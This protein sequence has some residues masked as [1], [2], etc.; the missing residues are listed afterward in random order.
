MDEDK[1][2]EKEY[3]NFVGIILGNKTVT[4]ILFSSFNGIILEII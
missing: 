3:S 4:P 1:K 2:R